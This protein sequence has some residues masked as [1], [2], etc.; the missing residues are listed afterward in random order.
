MQIPL[1]IKTISFALVSFFAAVDE[2]YGSQ[3]YNTQTYSFKTIKV[4][5][6]TLHLN[7]S[8]LLLFLGILLVVIG[9]LLFII[10]RRRKKNTSP[11]HTPQVTPPQTS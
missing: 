3:A 4:G 9:T 5:G 1:S 11:P 2:G 7:A 8:Y 6:F 10:A